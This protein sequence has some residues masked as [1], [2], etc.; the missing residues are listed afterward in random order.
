V[1]QRLDVKRS[2]LL[3][4]VLLA[5]GCGRD[6]PPEPPRS[7]SGAVT[8]QADVPKL[9]HVERV[10]GGA[11]ASERL[12]LVVAIHGLGDRPDAFGSLFNG[13]SA[14]ARFVFPEG[15]MPH[16]DG[17]SW[18]PI[19]RLEPQALAEGTSAAAR[20][21]AALLEELERTRPT[22]GRPIVTGFSQGGMLSFTLAANHPERVGEVF[23]VAGLLAPPLYPSAWP[24]GKT[25]PPIHAFHGEE[26]PIIPIAS[27]RETVRALVSVGF[28]AELTSYPGVRHTVSTE[29]R[30]D[31][32]AK[33][34]AAI[35]RAA[36]Q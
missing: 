9:R 25:T 5:P 23:P 27:A 15:I 22:A 16:G 8:P 3:V 4:L 11:D 18:F 10:T 7:S 24:M 2:L 32:F 28:S 34:N 1:S 17:F 6:A 29:M 19:A 20:A 13:I 33:L 12:P 14:R 21:L 35:Q 36:S 30:R 31:L 26:D